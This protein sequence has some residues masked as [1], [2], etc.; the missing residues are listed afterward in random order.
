LEEGERE[1]HERE[2]AITRKRMKDQLAKNAT[3]IAGFEDRFSEKVHVVSREFD[4]RIERLTMMIRATTRTINDL[5]ARS[6][7]EATQV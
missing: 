7:G 3:T 4:E 2:K 6:R 1:R 5:N